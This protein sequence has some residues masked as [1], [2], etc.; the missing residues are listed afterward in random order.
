MKYYVVL[1]NNTSSC[2]HKKR[3]YHAERK[4]LL[5]VDQLYR[6]DIYIADYDNFEAARE[7]VDNSL[8]ISYNK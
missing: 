6:G 4:Y 7:I 2:L 1:S 3:F 5:V 8:Q